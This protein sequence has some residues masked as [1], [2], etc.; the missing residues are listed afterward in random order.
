MKLER[1]QTLR[2]GSVP[3]RA[4][5]TSQNQHRFPGTMGVVIPHPSL[6]LVLSFFLPGVQARHPNAKQESFATV[7]AMSETWDFAREERALGT[8]VPVSC[9][10]LPCATS[11]EWLPLLLFLS[12]PLLGFHSYHILEICLC[13]ISPKLVYKFLSTKCIFF[14]NKT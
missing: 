10:S 13:I 5:K 4:G 7:T 9:A 3:D 11:P 1:Q 2:K 12:Q 6:H 14:C 8:G